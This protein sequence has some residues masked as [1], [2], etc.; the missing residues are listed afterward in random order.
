VIEPQEA[1]TN[2]AN[3][4]IRVCST[5]SKESEDIFRNCEGNFNDQAVSATSARGQ[6][7]SS[8]SPTRPTF[9]TRRKPS[10]HRASLRLVSEIEQPCAYVPRGAPCAKTDL[11]VGHVDEHAQQCGRLTRTPTQFYRLSIPPSIRLEPPEPA[12]RPLPTLP[13]KN[14]FEAPTSYCPHPAYP[15]DDWAVRTPSPVKSIRDSITTPPPG[16]RKEQSRS[17]SALINVFTS[18]WRRR[19]TQTPDGTVWTDGRGDAQSL[20]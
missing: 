15:V 9:T 6:T 20:P 12:V 18:A 5:I 8:S 17:T 7:R 1:G 2:Q 4:A 3:E 13:V 19:G 11:P 10:T 14:N 16:R